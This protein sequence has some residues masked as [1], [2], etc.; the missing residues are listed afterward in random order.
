MDGY[1]RWRIVNGEP[2]RESVLE[3]E[4]NVSLVGMGARNVRGE[5]STVA[6]PSPSPAGS[7]QTPPGSPPPRSS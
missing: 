4:L 2:V 7:A 3:H 5:I 6:S 1:H